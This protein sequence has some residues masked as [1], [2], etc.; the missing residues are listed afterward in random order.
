MSKK[1]IY[2]AGKM[3]GIP[4]FNF[5]AFDA[6]RDR[7]IAEGWEVISPADMDRDVGF[8]PT[9][10]N[11][12][13]KEFLEEAMKRDIDAIYR[14]DAIYMLDGWE[15]SIGAVAEHAIAKWR[16]IDVLYQSCKKVAESATSPQES[17]NPKDIV[18]SKKC[19]MHLLPP[20]AMEKIAWVHGLGASKY[21]PYNWRE[22]KISASQ[23]VAAIMRHLMA[24]HNMEDNDTESGITHLAHIG[25]TVNILMDAQEHVCLLDDRPKHPVK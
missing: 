15:T 12:V 25:A 23:Y 1:L 8:D 10:D 3:T 18:G 6:A 14:C 19:P 11:K 24:W 21:L 7:L 9:I 20:V 13:S 16:H 2:V 17:C 4:E 22:K 5:P